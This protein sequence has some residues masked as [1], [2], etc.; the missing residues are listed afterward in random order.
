MNS[1]YPAI[2]MVDDPLKFMMHP[3]PQ[4]RTT[5]EQHQAILA[6]AQ[7]AELI[8]NIQ[9][10]FAKY[11]AKLLEFKPGIE[12]GTAVHRMMERELKAATP[13]AMSCHKGC[14]GCCHYE[15]EITRNEAEILRS[16]VQRGVPIDYKRLHLQ[17]SRERRSPE[18]RRF[19]SPENRC[20]FLGSDGA[21]QVYEERPSICRKHL[22]TTPAANCTTDGATVLPIQVLLAEILLSA[23]L[24]IEGNVFG[25]LAKM[26]EAALEAMPVLRIELI[27]D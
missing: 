10:I 22:V 17:A 12:R 23:E 14:S 4:L 6:P 8:A 9:S 11:T 18:W 5:L 19:G 13:L 16:V 25:S 3:T 1:V 27:P 24:S 2:A 20:V 21:C 7:F 26:L 15:V